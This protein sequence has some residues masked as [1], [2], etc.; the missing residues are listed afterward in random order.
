M[1]KRR[2]AREFALQVLFQQDINRNNWEDGITLFWE[3]TPAD[4]ET[5][6]FTNL[7]VRGTMEHLEEIDNLIKKYTRH[8]DINRMAVVDRNLLRSSIYELLYFKGIPPKVTINEAIELAK[9]F[10]TEDSA[11]FINGILDRVCKEMNLDADKEPKE[12][13]A[14]NPNHT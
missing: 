9:T 12:Q 8:W 3:I 5:I 2:R 7:L 1:G 6:D 4:P 10:G 11:R 13:H 14:P